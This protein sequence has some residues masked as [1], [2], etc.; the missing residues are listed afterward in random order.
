[1]A[2]RNAVILWIHGKCISDPDKEIS[3]I[4][5][6]NNQ[7]RNDLEMA[8]RDFLNLFLRSTAKVSTGLF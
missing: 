6:F 5:F 8:C 4:E 3:I 7:G 1:M 2:S